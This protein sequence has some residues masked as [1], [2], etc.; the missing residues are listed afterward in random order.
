MLKI[1]K[2]ILLLFFLLI[3]FQVESKSC[4]NNCEYSLD[5]ETIIITGNGKINPVLFLDEND[6]DLFEDLKILKIEGDISSVPE[7]FMNYFQS[8]E[9]IAINIPI[10]QEGM[11]TNSMIKQVVIGGNVEII[12]SK[13]FEN[14]IYLDF[15]KFNTNSKLRK[16][17]D[18]AFRN[19]ISLESISFPKSLQ[20]IVF[21]TVLDNCINLKDIKERSVQQ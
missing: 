11:F 18:F 13:A 9:N 5:N 1:N 3:L 12:Q 17:E 4:G 14:C 2:F 8:V 16:I 10:I 6:L 15:I 7:N 21:Y 19:C 20:N